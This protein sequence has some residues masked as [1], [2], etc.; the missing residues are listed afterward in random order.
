MKINFSN[1]ELK[2]TAGLAKQFPNDNKPEIALSGRSNVGKSSLINKLI[3]RQSL[4][5]VSSS[6]GTTIT[7]NF[8]EIDKAIYLVDLPGYGFA[9]RP[10]EDK[11]KWSKLTD[12]YFTGE[13][14]LPA[15]VIQLIDLKVGPTTDD[16]QMLEYLYAMNIPYFVVA[17]KADKPNKTDRAK[18]L[19]KMRK[20]KSLEN[21][22]IIP[23]SSLSG[24]GKNEVLDEIV[25]YLG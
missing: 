18:M 3:G 24:E 22:P 25:K 2:I 11:A 1:A 20:I 14:G 7:V 12:G 8:Y 23:F 13:R 16:L 21:C 5:R 4:A 9:K 15:A 6:P 10:L 17:T 19:E